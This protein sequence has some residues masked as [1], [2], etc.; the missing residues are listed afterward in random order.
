MSATH[1]KKLHVTKA[2]GEKVNFLPEKLKY[3]L[4]RSGA[5]DEPRYGTLSKDGIIKAL[6]AHGGKITVERT[7][8]DNNIGHIEDPE[9]V[10]KALMRMQQDKHP[11]LIVTKNKE[12]YGVVDMENN[13]EYMMI[14][15]AKAASVNQR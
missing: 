9:P 1:Q 8:T 14:I 5:D 12:L 4:Q 11:L 6:T 2:S 3:S 13:L 10:E 15:N 7:V